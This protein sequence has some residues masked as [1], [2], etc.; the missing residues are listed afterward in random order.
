MIDIATKRV[1][2]GKIATWCHQHQQLIKLI[3]LFN[4]VKVVGGQNYKIQYRT[5]KGSSV[6]SKTTII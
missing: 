1:A 5:K 4:L 3:S 2:A 6:G